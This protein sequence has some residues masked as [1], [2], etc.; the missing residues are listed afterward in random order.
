MTRRVPLRLPV[1]RT[2][3]ALA[4][5]ALTAVSAACA[6]AGAGAAPAAAG[7]S[8]ITVIDNSH[9]DSIVEVDRSANLQNGS[10]TSG[11]DHDGSAVDVLQALVGSAPAPIP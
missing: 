6:L 2:P 4:A 7:D 5:A 1:Q 3:A 10:G 9:A 11:S 8:L